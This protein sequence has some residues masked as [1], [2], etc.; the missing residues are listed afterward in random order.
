MKT[1]KQHGEKNGFKKTSMK[2]PCSHKTDL[3]PCFYGLFSNLFFGDGEDVSSP[4]RFFPKAVVDVWWRVL[5]LKVRTLLR[6]SGG[7]GRVQ[8]FGFGF[9]EKNKP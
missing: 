2:E 9:F 3:S 5:P 8:G 7:P 1:K 6:C 4:W